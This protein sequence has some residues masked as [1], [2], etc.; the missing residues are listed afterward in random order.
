[1]AMEFDKSRTERSDVRAGEPPQ[2]QE[3]ALQDAKTP[4]GEIRGT[5]WRI[6]E[7]QRL[8]AAIIPV[9]AA[10]CLQDMQASATGDPEFPDLCF[11][12]QLRDGRG[13]GAWLLPNPAIFV[14]EDQP[15]GFSEPDGG[16]K[17][18]AL[19]DIFSNER[20][21]K[22]AHSE[23]FFSP[24]TLELRLTKGDFDA[25]VLTVR[26]ENPT[27][28]DLDRL[29]ERAIQTTREPQDGENPLPDEEEA[30][31]KL[32]KSKPS[33]QEVLA[34]AE[35]RY[36]HNESSQQWSYL[37]QEIERDLRALIDE[38]C[39]AIDSDEPI[40]IASISRL[41]EPNCIAVSTV[42]PTIDGSYPEV[43]ICYRIA[44][45]AGAL[46]LTR[47]GVREKES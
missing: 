15:D 9:W 20:F 12:F 42:L 8:F 25:G 5:E 32:R 6:Y 27:T 24:V 45:R 31:G 37:R 30:P 22:P 29:I 23:K 3:D 18:L 40:A 46:E 10:A 1:M 43:E 39:F 38:H 41:P 33:L 14:P 7:G 11:K 47:T 44:F 4:E 26:F 28:R 35:E 19:K 2:H 34:A 36:A 13:R 16:P 21:D 17:K